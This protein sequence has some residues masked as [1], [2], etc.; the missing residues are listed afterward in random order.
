MTKLFFK[1]KDQFSTSF[2]RIFSV[3]QRLVANLA[4]NGDR[5]CWNS[6]DSVKHEEWWLLSHLA[7]RNYVQVWT[8][9]VS[10]AEGAKTAAFAFNF[11]TRIMVG[12]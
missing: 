3:K 12:Q 5:N 8:E 7:F 1:K 6:N 9:V 2:K 10:Y 4:S 11:Q